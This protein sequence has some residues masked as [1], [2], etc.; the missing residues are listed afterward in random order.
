MSSTWGQLTVV[1]Q[2]QSEYSDFFKEVNGYRP[3]FMST[4][5]WNSEE[6]L[7]SKLNAL[8][9]T[10]K[11][12]FAAE[13]AREDAAAVKF[14]KNVDTIIATGAGDRKTALRWILDANDSTDDPDYLCC[15]LGLPYGYFT[16]EQ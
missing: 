13:A 10:S 1:E 5:Q 15:T 6:W 8:E 11:V 9:E 3:R 7:R 14:E 4:E 2:L 16:T 12:V